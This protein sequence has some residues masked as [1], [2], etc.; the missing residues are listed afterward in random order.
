MCVD[1]VDVLGWDVMREPEAVQLTHPYDREH[2][3]EG[4]AQSEHEVANTG[5]GHAGS[6]GDPVMSIGSSDV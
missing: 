2:G 6:L 3:S 4:A 5:E 1:P